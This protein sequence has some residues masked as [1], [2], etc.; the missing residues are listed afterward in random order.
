MAKESDRRSFSPPIRFPFVD[1]HGK[2]VNIDRRTQP[3]RRLANIEVKEDHL[4]FDRKRF[5]NK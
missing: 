3:D 5:I 4:N 2:I 1:G